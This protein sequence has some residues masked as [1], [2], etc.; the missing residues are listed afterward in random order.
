MFYICSQ[1]NEQTNKRTNIVITIKSTKVMK[2]EVSVYKDQELVERKTV[3][4]VKA[5]NVVENKYRSRMTMN[6]WVKENWA[7]FR[8]YPS[9]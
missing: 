8:R 1:T 9:K 6:Q 3:N 7:V 2:V 4:G 5:S